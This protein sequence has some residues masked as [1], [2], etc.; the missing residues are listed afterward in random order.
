MK[1]S[2]IILLLTFYEFPNIIGQSRSDIGQYTSISNDSIF[3][4]GGHHFRYKGLN[5]N[6]ARALKK[7]LNLDTDSDLYESARKYTRTK[8][9]STVLE[10][11]GIG[12]IGATVDG[13]IV[14]ES[15][16]RPVPL[17]IGL[18]SLG[19]SLL[20][21]KKSKRQFN[22][23]IHDYNHAVHDKYIQER[24]NNQKMIPTSQI[25]IGV[26]IKF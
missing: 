5:F 24:F 17:I 9:L 11:V 4:L 14:P 20:L 13:F 2:L 3:N 12:S 23:F 22:N 21:W 25:N 8:R 7:V 26:K 1:T 6:S 10:F 15:E 16:V 19:T 18:A